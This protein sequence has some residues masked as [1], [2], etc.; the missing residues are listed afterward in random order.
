MEFQ[1]T[2]LFYVDTAVNSLIVRL[3]FLAS[4]NDFLLAPPGPFKNKFNGEWNYYS[5]PG[6]V[7]VVCNFYHFIDDFCSLPFYVQ[8][9]D[10]VDLPVSLFILH[11]VS[12]L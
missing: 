1:L 2:L 4:I 5:V 8:Y 6:E 12:T 3:T 11:D 7:S 10:A 9:S